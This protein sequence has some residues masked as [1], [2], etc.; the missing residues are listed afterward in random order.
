M[1]FSP[2]KFLPPA[3]AN[4]YVN[5]INGSDEFKQFI[6]NR[7]TY[8]NKII[9]EQKSAGVFNETKKIYFSSFTLGTK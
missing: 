4:S 1:V 9:R 5:T 2:P 6:T 3:N 8:W 7:I